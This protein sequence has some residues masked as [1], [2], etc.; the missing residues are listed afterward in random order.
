MLAKRYLPAV[1]SP[2]S[3]V[4]LTVL[5]VVYF[6]AA[7]FGLQF[8]FIHSS[9]TAVWAPTGIALAAVLVFGYDV[10]PGIF[11]GAFVINLLT[12]GNLATSLGIAAGNTLEAMVGAYLVNRFAGGARAME[13]ARDILLFG[14]LAGIVSTT[15]SPT[16]GLTSLCLGGF[17]SWWDFSAIWS[18]W[19]LGDCVG[20]LAVAPALLI[21]SANPR[22]RLTRGDAA[23]S[24]EAV[25]LLVCLGL[26]SLALFGGLLPPGITH[27][28]LEFLCVPTLLWAAYRFSPRGVATAT[29]VLAGIALWGTRYGYG[30]FTDRAPNTSLVLLQTFIGF[31]SLLSLT[32][33]GVVTE[34][35]GAEEQ[36]RQMALTDP[37]TGLA[38]YREFMQALESEIARSSRTSRPFAILFLDVDHLKWINDTA[39]HLA[40]SQ[41]I[42]RV[43][44]ALRGSCRNVDTAARI[45]GDEF[46]VILPETAVERAQDLLGRIDAVLAA[47]AQ[48]PA[49]SVSAGVAEHPRDGATAEAL[50]SAA[51]ALLYGAKARRNSSLVR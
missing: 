8:A 21:W 1:N 32:F 24:V 28:P 11:V 10:W 16:I 49:V 25:A 44:D 30:P 9:A 14:F 50:L 39:G 47:D 42:R 40:G 37:L 46:A 51:D 43:A 3:V 36:I 34:R 26:I 18:T 33:A 38:N 31:S 17:A 29:L 6:I 41:A 45:G 35:R 2:R 7:K 15:V 4:I 23:K 5:A 20:N 22:V 27:Y 48:E 12:A 19:W 13:R